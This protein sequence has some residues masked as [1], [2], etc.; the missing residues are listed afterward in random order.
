VAAQVGQTAAAVELIKRSIALDP[1][2][3][4]FQNNLGNVLCGLGQLDEAITA[5]RRALELDPKYID[6]LG[7]LGNALRDKGLMDE[8]IETFRRA[9]AL[10]PRYAEA[11]NNLG[12]ALRDTRR[13]DEA[14]AA[15]TEARRLLPT[16]AEVHNNL[17]NVLK[18]KGRLDDAIASYREALRLKPTHTKAHSNLLFTLA[19]HPDYDG[20][21]I[22]QESARLDAQHGAP[23][24]SQ[25]IPF[26]NDPN[27]QRRLKIGYVS[28]DFRDHCQ[29]L[30]TIPLLAHQDHSAFEILC[31]A[32][33][34]R[35]DALTD[36]I[37][38]YADVWRSTVG[39]TDAQ[40]ANLIR[41]DGID[42][43]VDLTMHMSLGRP[44]VFA[45]KPAPVQIAWLAYPG[46]TGLSTM[47][48]RLTDPQLDPPEQGDEFYREKSIRLPNT[49]WCYDPLT[50][51]PTP[52]EVPALA[53]G[54]ITFG[55]LNNFCKVTAPTISLWAEVLRAVP[56]SRMLIMSSAGDH[57]QGLLDMMQKENVDPGRIEFVPFQARR[58]YL[59]TY[60]RIDIGLDTIPYNGHTTSLDSFWMGVPVVTRVGRTVVGRAGF[61]QLCNL[62]LR[63]LA[64]ESDE[65]F[66]RIASG[67][68]GD[69]NR[70]A[71]LRSTLREKMEKSPLMDGERFAKDIEETYRAVWREFTRRPTAP[72]SS[73]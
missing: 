27:P 66:V 39:L 22:F 7:N 21:A 63:E 61:S 65:E 14:L 4:G 57:R 19:Y 47:D 26:T 36:R 30:F 8:A 60:R 53:A 2:A 50:T 46:T 68:A 33:I 24:K 58:E 67:L 6:P 15:F 28:P 23:L 42:I 44:L 69:L 29:S 72:R 73:C 35:P 64:A 12:I 49:F 31:Y 52:G 18:D 71:L 43:L 51:E 32:D 62:N 11:F 10:N 3:A 16:L 25:I 56:N 45:R 54:H 34:R 48:Y 55:C 20:A 41:S 59:E 17:G 9:V 70:L 13:L 38:G 37:R 1:R 5:Y 40:V